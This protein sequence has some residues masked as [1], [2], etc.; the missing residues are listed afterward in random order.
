MMGLHQCAFGGACCLAGGSE[1]DR[2]SD[3]ADAV[4]MTIRVGDTLDNTI[5]TT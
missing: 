5:A 4:Q 2:W 1:A 3:A